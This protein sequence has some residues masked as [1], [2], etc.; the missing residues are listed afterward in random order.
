[1]YEVLFQYGPFT[2]RTLYVFSA[3][4]FLA[5]MI[6]LMRYASRKKLPASF[7]AS[8]LALFLI[9]GLLGGRIV[10]I[11]ENLSHYG[12]NPLSALFIWDLKLSAFGAFYAIIA[13]LY[14]LTRSVRETFWAWFDAF[15]L[16]G[17]VGLIFIH[18][19][20]FFNGTHYGK[21]TDMPWGM[22]F[23]TLNIPFLNP[24]H[25]TQ[26]YSVLLTFLIFGFAMKYNR[27]THLYGMVGSLTIM[28]YC[29]SAFAMDFLHGTPSTYDKISFLSIAGI[30]LI[31]FISCSHQTY[32]QKNSH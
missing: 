5:T 17:M 12:Q 2:L 28:L 27:R 19:G 23:D 29:L 10:H 30:A 18:L 7:L 4:A 15:I 24:I 9:T 20:H 16:S 6:F 14:A 32:Y 3:L 21:P 25:P 13:T 8:H 22:T 26:L 11:L 1:M 31:L